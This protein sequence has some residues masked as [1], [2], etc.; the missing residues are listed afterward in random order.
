MA[1]EITSIDLA[2]LAT[3][4]GAS[5]MRSDAVLDVTVVLLEAGYASTAVGPI[6]VFHSAGV[7]WNWLQRDVSQPRFRVRVAS[8]DG[9]PVT[10]LCSL[11]L[12]PEFAIDDIQRSDIVILPAS[13]WDVQDQIAKDTHLLPWLRKMHS[14]GA[15]I[16]G[17]CT[18]VA[19]LAESGLLDGRQAT[20]HWALAENFR[21]R[22]PNVVWRPEN[23]VTEDGRLLCSGGVYAS[24][25][26]EL[27]SRR[28]VLWPRHRA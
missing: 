10:S 9:A 14:R 2:K 5:P 19:F 13:G 25:G 21:Q 16:A 27:V 23:F 7:L 26:S 11:G 28:E 17:V 12:V 8:I 6:E 22:Y 15:Y 4:R 18:G 20:T 3:R 24:I 1:T